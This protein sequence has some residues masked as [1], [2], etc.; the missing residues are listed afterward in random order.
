VTKK[1]ASLCIKYD[2][3]QYIN[4]IIAVAYE[5]GN[6]SICS[7][8]RAKMK[9]Y[10]NYPW[11]WDC[12]CI[13]AMKERNLSIIESNG[14]VYEKQGMMVP[15]NADLENA[16]FTLPAQCEAKN[17]RLQSECIYYLI[18]NWSSPKDR[19]D[20]MRDRYI[21]SKCLNQLSGDDVHPE[22][23]PLGNEK[24]MYLVLDTEQN[25]DFCDGY[26]DLMRRNNN[27]VGIYPDRNQ[28]FDSCMCY[29][30]RF[31]NRTFN[32]FRSKA[33]A[34]CSKLISDMG[35]VYYWQ[36]AHRTN[37]PDL[38]HNADSCIIPLAIKLKNVSICDA[39]SRNSDQYI[40]CVDSIPLLLTA[41]QWERFAILILPTLVSVVIGAIVLGRN[42]AMGLKIRYL[43]LSAVYIIV[44]LSWIAS[45][46][47]LGS[48]SN[49]DVFFDA[50]KGNLILKTNH[51]NLVFMPVSGVVWSILDV[52]IKEKYLTYSLLYI[53]WFFQAG[54]YVVVFPEFFKIADEKLKRRLLYGSAA[55]AALMCILSV[56][57]Y[58]LTFFLYLISG[59]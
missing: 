1:N 48:S 27:V 30:E 44:N 54:F 10:T 6:P 41:D 39:L 23:V 5:S 34:N 35:E 19:C 52:V 31:S 2:D 32:Q 51:F 15:W 37:N 46:L 33:I 42:Y 8:M 36:Y 43:V 38:C 22:A 4:C 26:V 56:I 57:F 49:F 14:D 55:F 24:E 16:E 3:G 58:S 53:T 9:G 47:S 28:D 45:L 20:L 59:H 13:L 12:L 50:A 18:K 25:A 11:D 40:F 29:S 21:R 17:D 7:Q